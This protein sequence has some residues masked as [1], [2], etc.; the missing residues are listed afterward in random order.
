[1]AIDSY[2]N[3]LAPLGKAI[4]ALANS[5]VPAGIVICMQY[6]D[7]YG[8]KISDTYLLS[9]NNELDSKTILDAFEEHIGSGDILAR[10]YGLPNLAPIS[11]EYEDGGPSGHCYM[12]VLNVELVY[13]D[14]EYAEARRDYII[15]DNDISIVVDA[16][17][18]G[19]VKE[20]SDI[21]EAARKSA[22][23]SHI[24]ALEGMG[25]VV[26]SKAE[27]D[28]LKAQT[29]PAH[30]NKNLL[31]TVANVGLTNNA[32]IQFLRDECRFKMSDIYN[33]QAS[34]QAIVERADSE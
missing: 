16:A 20:W 3:P 8:D 2:S 5:K 12:Q 28:T 19:G 22:A 26:R 30:I 13:T 27:E 32:L 31:I 21:E 10:Q 11:T 4:T 33:L 7:G 25:Y 24:S 9:N 6:R 17:L 23:N 34:L 15:W 14:A 29:L 1:M 18:N